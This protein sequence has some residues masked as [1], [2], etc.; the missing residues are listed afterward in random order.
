MTISPSGH[1]SSPA[2]QS[3]PFFRL[4]F[5]PLFWLGAL[6]SVLS[7]A[8]WGLAFTGK[9]PFSPYGGVYFWHSHE[10]LFGFT[11]AI[12]AGFLLTAV[13][14]WT[15]VP[16]I[17]GPQLMVLVLLWLIARVLMAFPFS[18]STI[19]ITLIDSVFM[20]IVAVFM[21]IPVIKA[22][23]WR[24]LFFVPVLVLMGVLNLLM[25]LSLKG[26]LAMSFIGV[27]HAMILLVALVMCILGGRVFPMFTANGTQTERVPPLMWLEKVSIIAVVVSVLV[28]VLA[29]LQWLQIS[30]KIEAAI[31]ILA[32]VAN[33]LRALRW[34]IWVSFKTPLVWS[35]H[36]SY[37]ALCLG[38]CLLGL[39]KLQVFSSV[40][41]ALHAI[42]VGGMGLMI[43]S[44][45]SR[46]SLGH[47]GRKI[48]V[49]KIMSLAFIL[50]I[51]G[52][53]ARVLAPL[54][55]NS[56]STLILLAS[57]LWCVAYGCFVVMYLPVLFTTRADG[58]EG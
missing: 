54:V 21:A 33:F 49:G 5:R 16:S 12:I 11:A 2:A 32:G 40:S 17:K 36:L 44:M 57:A 38:L 14:N 4:A 50:M 9:L 13:Q 22:K 58:R 19:L 28:S 48:E 27:S 6:F 26:T 25:H 43:L 8:V 10:M 51:L 29:V 53:V 41:L 7:I 34:R 15:G 37:W 30:P 20:P 3:L 46:V 24:N 18:V 23:K 35:L 45:I 47:T 42:T 39:A 1:T 56:Y 31:L 55:L 52:F